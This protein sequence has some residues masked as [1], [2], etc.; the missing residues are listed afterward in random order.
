MVQADKIRMQSKQALL[1]GALNKMIKSEFS[2]IWFVFFYIY[3]RAKVTQLWYNIKIK[4]T[5]DNG[6]SVLIYVMGKANNLAFV[7]MDYC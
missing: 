3:L 5:L 7:C 1:S 6:T 4:I 2:T